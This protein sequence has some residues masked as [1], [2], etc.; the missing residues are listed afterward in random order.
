V[1]ARERGVVFHQGPPAPLLT[2]LGDRKKI[3]WL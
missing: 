3:L 2:D 1:F